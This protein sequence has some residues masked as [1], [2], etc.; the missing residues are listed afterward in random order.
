[1]ET[2]GR[3]SVGS[4]RR[5][6][7]LRLANGNWSTFDL[8]QPILVFSMIIV[9]TGHLDRVLTGIIAEEA[10]AAC[11]EQMALAAA[12]AAEDDTQA[13]TGSG[14]VYKTIKAAK[15][16]ATSVYISKYLYVI[17]VPLIFVLEG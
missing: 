12:E 3:L 5:Q 7:C 14:Q 1:M 11:Q 4:M 17:F 16:A 8:P 15:T 13:S 6:H 9:F 2:V 10:L